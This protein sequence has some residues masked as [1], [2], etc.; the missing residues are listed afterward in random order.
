M[1][2][3]AL[4]AQLDVSNMN[5]AA[6]APVPATCG[7]PRARDH[8]NPEYRI[9]DDVRNVRVDV[10]NAA[11]GQIFGCPAGW[12]PS[13]LQAPRHHTLFAALNAITYL[14]AGKLNLR[15]PT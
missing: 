1:R 2:V 11:S 10:S 6:S 5:D 9:A 12:R 15:L 4:D 13:Q 14:I 3:R 7:E 8:A